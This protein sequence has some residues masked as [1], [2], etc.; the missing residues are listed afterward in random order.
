MFIVF[1]AINLFIRLRIVEAFQCYNCKKFGHKGNYCKNHVLSQ[2][3]NPVGMS[4]M[5]MNFHGYYHLCNDYGHKLISV[6]IEQIQQ[7]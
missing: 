4:T 1:N 3:H 2:N 5:N 6:D 7:I